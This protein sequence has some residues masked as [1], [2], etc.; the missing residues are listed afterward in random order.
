MPVEFI[1]NTP[2]NLENE[3]K[4]SEWLQK[5]IVSEN[6]STGEIVYAFFNDEELKK[7]NN[8]HLGHNYYTDV[9]SFNDS[10]EKVLSGN[11][12][13]SVD[14]VKEN[15][16][17]FNSTFHEEMRRVMLHGLLHLMGYNDLIEK[18]KTEMRNKED[19]ILSVFHVEQ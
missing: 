16:V 3:K 14:R 12:A 1:Y 4:T 18:E 2:F 17:E 6:F 19:E 8:K 15:S 10:N 7:L 13:I 5:A 9:I 11:I